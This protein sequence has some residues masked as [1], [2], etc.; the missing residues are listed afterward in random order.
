MICLY[1][2]TS[3]DQVLAY[4]L[5]FF[6]VITTGLLPTKN[7]EMM[8]EYRL[9][10]DFC[11]KLELVNDGADRGIK[12]IEHFS[13]ITENE[14]QFQFL[15]Q[16]VEVEDNRKSLPSFF[17]KMIDFNY[18]TI[19]KLLCF[20]L[21]LKYFHFILPPLFLLN[22]IDAGPLNSYRFSKL[23]GQM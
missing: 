19:V 5:H 15:L 8:S 11:F 1:Y 17:H 10:R 20:L 9:M 22:K 3:S 13:H 18:S 14:D 6:L 2:Q 16:C 4:Y 23:F 21:L 7:W 12:I